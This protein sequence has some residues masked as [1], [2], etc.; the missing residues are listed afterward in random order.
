MN[1]H[2]Q[3]LSPRDQRIVRWGAALVS[4]LLFWAW[5]WD[6][7]SASRTHLREQAVQNEAS[8]AWMRPAAEQLAARGGVVAA[9]VGA[10]DGRSLLARVDA[11]AR[12]AG[13]GAHLTG[14]SPQGETRVQMQFSAVEFDA[15]V[16]WL[17][18]QRAAG[19]EI[20]AL[21][22]VRAAGSGRTDA[23]VSLQAAR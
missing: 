18:S 17:E 23:Q 1:E 4:A 5:V 11:S 7:L 16:S 14:V 20:E 15:L 22:V 9:A 13:L 2:W 8:L 10:D 3:A 21:G 12:A 6:P 19:I